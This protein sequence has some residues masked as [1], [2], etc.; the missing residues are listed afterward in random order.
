LIR[1]ILDQGL[2]RSTATWLV[3]AGWDVQHVA[4]IEMARAL[5][6]LLQR[7]WPMISADL[8]RGSMAT[9][10]TR[11]VRMHHLPIGQLGG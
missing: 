8:D 10:T 2:P 6:E 5:A 4:D 11:S 3:A 7:V 9:I 1:L